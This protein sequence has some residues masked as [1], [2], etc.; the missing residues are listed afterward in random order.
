MNVWIVTAFIVAAAYIM[1]FPLGYLV[2]KMKTGKDIRDF[3]SGSGGAT[4]VSNLLGTRW[5]IG[6]AA[7]DVIKG[8]IPS[9]LFICLFGPYWMTGLVAIFSVL[10]NIF[11]VL[12][13]PPQFK[14]GKGVATTCGALLPM[15]VVSLINYHPPGII[16]VFLAIIGIWVIFV[17]MFRHNQNKWMVLASSFLIWAMVVFFG[18]LETQ[19]YYT[20]SAFIFLIAAIVLF[21]HR[22]NYQDLKEFH[23]ELA[24]AKRIAKSNQ[25]RN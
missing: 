9:T 10:G 8:A 6:V 16:V 24:A 23:E 17:R 18:F 13:P 22:R 21:A 20:F 11:P 1:G 25:E 14:G 3:R 7:G 2:V 12:I 4:N 19:T 15:L 5:G